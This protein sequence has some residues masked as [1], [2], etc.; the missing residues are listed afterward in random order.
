MTIEEAI[1]ILD[2]GDWWDWLSEYIPE[3]KKSKLFD[4]LD[5]ANVALRAQLEVEKNEPLTLDELRE[6]DGEPVWD[7][8][9]LVWGIVLMDLCNGKGAVKH[10]D[11]GF[12]G[13]FEQLSEKRFY[14]HKPKDGGCI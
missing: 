9:Y 8:Y 3:E 5:T 7:N 6:M 4:A 10:C 12:D 2:N 1:R 14:R 13:A 11:T